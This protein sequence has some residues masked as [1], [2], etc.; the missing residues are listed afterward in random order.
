MIPAQPTDPALTT[1]RP[2]ARPSAPVP[3][4]EA[5]SRAPV[6]A[7]VPASAPTAADPAEAALAAVEHG[8]A[9]LGDALTRADIAAIESASAELQ[10]VLRAALAQFAALARRGTLPAP[11]HARFSRLRGLVGVQREAISR[12]NAGV[13]QHLE[14]LLP[15]PHASASVYSP[16]GGG[17]GPG[18]MLAAS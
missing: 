13:E 14:I 12:A 16:Q 9:A 8:L 7:S 5:P 2:A 3:G 15:K 17:R 6:S 18:R 4:R 11:L 1:P 10:A